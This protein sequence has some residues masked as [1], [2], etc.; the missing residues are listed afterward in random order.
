MGKAFLFSRAVVVELGVLCMKCAARAHDDEGS[1][2]KHERAL[3][4]AASL[5]VSTNVAQ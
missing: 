1:D 2:A 5:S 4:S 3:S